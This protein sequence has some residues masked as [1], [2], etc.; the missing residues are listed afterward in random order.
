MG[1]LNKNAEN[2]EAV[3]N[4]S[5]LDEY[6]NKVYILVLLLVPGACQCAGIAYTFEKIMGW[7]PSV[8]W[9]ALIIFDVTCLIYLFTGIF[10]V[11]TGFEN[12]IVK[13]S[14][15]KQGKVFLVL[16]MFIQYNFIL[17]MIPA[18]DFW[19]FA[20]FFVILTAFFLDSKMVA[21]TSVE[22]AASI[23]LSW[24]TIGDVMLPAEGEHFMVNL[25]DR[26]ICIALSLPTVVL[27]TYLIGRFLVNAKKDELE[28]NN[29]RVQSVISAAQELSE[30]LLSAGNAL[31]DISANESSTA[32]TLS[33]TSDSLLT[34]SDLLS[35]KADTSIANLNELT[36]CGSR[37]SENVEKVGAASR[38][39]IEKSAENEEALNMLMEVNGQVTS[40]MNK[41]NEVASRLS[42][43][44]EGIDLTLN[45]ISDIA[46]T[47]NILSLNATIEA[48]RAGEAGK[49]FAVVAHE[50][51]G[52]ANST[53]QSL[54]E[55]Q[56][57][58]ERVKENVKE[59]TA[60]VEENHEKLTLQNEYFSNV[61]ANMKEMN[62][63]L[64]SSVNDINTMNDVYT[65]Q[66]D[67]IRHTV[68][69]SEDIAGSIRAENN[70]FRSISD[71][72]DN[73]VRSASDMSV[74]I[75]SINRMAVQI[76]EILNS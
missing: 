2:K 75:E 67:I 69:I 29:A 4:L 71:M 25:L 51:G 9:T 16:I 15:L 76:D 31:S 42:E 14:K 21:V 12:G 56:K 68:D 52:L 24:F 20:F 27:L 23:V 11:K 40:S 35:K 73:N 19:G 44:V 43:A 36:E 32:D 57:I 55:I 33:A 64:R 63:L 46:M 74:Q 37:L 26:I 6:I 47:T 41:T 62:S 3:K 13:K 60:Y 48:A 5:A 34:N 45:L 39:L 17:Y 59:M 53:R 10:F 7:L 54:D 22:I 65:R 18:T 30:Q 50:V 72:V 61:F 49:S 8:S 1:I 38:D 66:S 28:R 70:E 58:V